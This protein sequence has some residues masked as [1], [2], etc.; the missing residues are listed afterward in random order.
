V[1]LATPEA[2]W[3]AAPVRL[4]FSFT[5]YREHELLST[6]LAE[7]ARKQKCAH[8]GVAV[9]SARA[10]EI[11]A[12]RVRAIPGLTEKHG[13]LGLVDGEQTRLVD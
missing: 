3:R 7:G 1:G 11:R 2:N 13:P 5:T 12:G 9:L 10:A 8:P 4:F 6:F